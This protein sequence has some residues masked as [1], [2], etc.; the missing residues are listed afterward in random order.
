MGG[1]LLAMAGVVVLV[2][3]VPAA[4]AARRDVTCANGASDATTIQDAIN[5]SNPGDEVVISGRCLLTSTIKLLDERTYRGEARSD[6]NGDGTLLR[7]ADG[8][9][10]PALVAT[11]TWYDDRPWVSSNIR[12]ENLTLDGNREANTGTIGLALQTWDSRVYDVKVQFTPGDGIRLSSVTRGGVSL[13]AGNNSVNGVIADV[14]VEHSGGAGIRVV[15]PGNHVTDWVLERSW[16]SDSGGSGV[17]LDNA[18]GWQVR[19]LHVYESARHAID[20]RRCYNAGIH[21]NYVEDFGIQGTVGTVY[22]G[23]R[24]T[25]QPG[26]P[27]TVIGNKINYLY[28]TL[29]AASYVYLAV[30]GQQAGASYAAVTGNAVVGRGTA[31]ETGLRYALGAGTALT[32]ASTGNLV[33]NVGTTRSVG[34]GVTVTAGQ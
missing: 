30:E 3:D 2:G 14:F 1:V 10:L 20:A 33:T 8:R 29:P 27:A 5:A 32:V 22:Y 19:D 34:T 18:A 26:T 7:Q 17:D 11:E 12:I 24:C 15:D 4:Q 28:G 25:L 16:I 21:D 23:I 13:A 9:N 6:R 31:R